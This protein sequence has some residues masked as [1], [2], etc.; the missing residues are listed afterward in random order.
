MSIPVGGLPVVG[1]DVGGSKVHGVLLADG[2][3]V[4]EARVPTRRGADGVVA[5]A[6]ETVR[7]L[8]TGLGP[9]PLAAVGVGVPG[10]VTVGT[11]V[12]AH[13]VNLGIEGPQPIGPRLSQALDGLPVVVEN[14]LNVSALGAVHVLGL[15]G[16]LAFLALGTGL[17]AGLVL[18]GRMRRGHRGAAGE[19]GHLG[20]DPSGPRCPCGQRG[21]LELYA[22]GSAIEARWS[23]PA[24]T[25]A[26]AEVFR[27]AATGDADAVAVRDRFADAVAAAVEVLALTTDVEH[28][29][30]GG[31]VAGV[32]PVLAEV[33][34][35]ALDRRA[36]GSPF[37]RALRV[38]DRLHVVPA[39]CPVA[40]VGAALAAGAVMADSPSGRL[41]GVTGTGTGEVA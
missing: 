41:V 14:D 21:C 19:V 24:G 26:A 4:R 10:I 32:G 1:L 7:A 28:V 37:L 11:G 30:L 5:A 33:V 35:R 13:A 27:A 8:R 17:A 22:S 12:V 9:S 31:G 29:V 25:P 20:Y 39:G 15:T 38:A 40:P 18:D 16:D 23:S 36:A 3:V 34:G 2:E 6:A